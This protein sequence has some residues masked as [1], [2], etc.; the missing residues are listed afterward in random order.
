[1][2]DECLQQS[3]A[4]AS[5]NTEISKDG[6]SA[7]IHTRQRFCPRAYICQIFDGGPITHAH[8]LRGAPFFSASDTNGAGPIPGTP[9]TTRDTVLSPTVREGGRRARARGI[10]EPN[11]ANISEIGPYG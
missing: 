1:M 6:R 2:G 10:R 5:T 11:I 7:P 8:A 4:E 3:E 9:S